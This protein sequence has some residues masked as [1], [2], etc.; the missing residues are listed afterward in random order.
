MRD[1]QRLLSDCPYSNKDLDAPAASTLHRI[2]PYHTAFYLRGFAWS[3]HTIAAHF[4]SFCI[5]WGKQKMRNQDLKHSEFRSGQVYGSIPYHAMPYHT[6]VVYSSCPSAWYVY[7]PP[8]PRRIHFLRS[9]RPEGLPPVAH[10][11]PL[12]K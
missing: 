10:F 5:F 2:L 9:T 11:P 6:M 4:N 8:P 3:H 7:R 1:P 12:A